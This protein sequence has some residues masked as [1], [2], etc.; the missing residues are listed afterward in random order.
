MEEGIASEWWSG[1]VHR[2][3]PDVVDGDRFAPGLFIH[4]AGCFREVASSEK[5]WR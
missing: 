1:E 5:T 3:V 4:S 2:L